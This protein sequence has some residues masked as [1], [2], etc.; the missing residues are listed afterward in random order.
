MAEHARQFAEFV[1]RFR[2]VA[3]D[4]VHRTQ[5]NCPLRKGLCWRSAEPVWA[6]AP[7]LLL[8]STFSIDKPMSMAPDRCPAAAI[9]WL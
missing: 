2:N 3:E 5:S 9:S 4:L 7:M 8:R 1:A 6:G